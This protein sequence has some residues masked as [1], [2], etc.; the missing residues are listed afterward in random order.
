[1]KKQILIA[2]SVCT[3]FAASAQK[4]D[5][6]VSRNYYYLGIGGGHQTFT[7]LNKRIATMPQYEQVKGPQFNVALGMLNEE[8]R[9]L[10]DFSLNLA[11]MLKGN[12]EKKS[13]T[14]SVF[15]F[16]I[17]FGYNLLP[18][19]KKIRL[20]PTAGVGFE[21][22][23]VRLNKD[24]SAIPFDSVMANPQWRLQ[25]EPVNFSNTYFTYNAGLA[26]DFLSRN[27]RNS[28]AGFRAG[29][30]GSFK[31]R[32]WRANDNQL[33]ANAPADRVNRWYVM[34]TLGMGGCKTAKR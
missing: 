27:S 23:R 3:V 34:L 17:N 26:I 5:S 11:S 30:T 8:G 19:S 22:V 4:K 7:N 14:S 2:L 1:M 13:S 28:F 18:A 31:S 10:S 12:D 15:N 16:N 24:L 20:Y 6:S 32:S 21:Y 9:F 25:T 33:L 29:Y